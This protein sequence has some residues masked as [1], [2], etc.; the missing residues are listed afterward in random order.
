[1]SWF[2]ERRQEGAR[3]PR[4]GEEDKQKA[5]RA[6]YEKTIEASIR[7]SLACRGKKPDD[8]E[9]RIKDQVKVA[10][11]RLQAL[12]EPDIALT[13]GDVPRLGGSKVNGLIG[14]QWVEPPGGRYSDDSPRYRLLAD[15]MQARSTMGDNALLNVVLEPCRQ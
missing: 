9:E 4:K 10:M 13:G 8:P 3:V 2:A 15:V 11:G 12:H 14:N 7:K 6:Q 5:M 1:M